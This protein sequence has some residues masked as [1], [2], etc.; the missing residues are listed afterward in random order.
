MSVSTRA[1]LLLLVGLCGLAAHLGG[2]VLLAF[3][4]AATLQFGL[5]GGVADL[6]GLRDE[7][8][9]I[10]VGTLSRG[11]R[12]GVRVPVTSG[13]TTHSPAHVHVRVAAVGHNVAMVHPWG[14][15][16][17]T[18]LVA[19]VGLNPL[20]VALAIL[21]LQPRTVRLIC[22]QTSREEAQR[23]TEVITAIDTEF[24]RTATDFA[25]PLCI[26]A[27][28][29]IAASAA[30][31]GY[32]AVL[33]QPFRLDYSG[34]TKVMTAAAVTEHLHSHASHPDSGGLWRTVVD[35]ASGTVINGATARRPHTRSDGL[36]IARIAALH[37]YTIS[38]TDLP[39]HGLPGL[40]DAIDQL[41]TRLDEIDKNSTTIWKSGTPAAAAVLPE[42]AALIG[43]HAATL[44]LPVDTSRL[45]D[46]AGVRGQLREI[47]VAH[48]LM[49]LV[50]GDPHAREFLSEAM[51]DGK[52]WEV[53]EDA[54][55]QTSTPATD[56]QLDLIVRSGHRVL[57]L[58]V[59]SQAKQANDY[60][61]ERLIP[62]R[63]PFGTA[64]TSVIASAVGVYLESDKS[65]F[66]SWDRVLQTA[67]QVQ[68]NL[69]SLRGK[70]TAWLVARETGTDEVTSGLRAW[71]HQSSAPPS[72]TARTVDR[73]LPLSEQSSI[74]V[75]ADGT[76]LAVKAALQWAGQRSVIALGPDTPHARD[77]FK[78]C[79]ESAKLA[80][81]RRDYLA[82]TIHGEHA[83][84]QALHRQRR[85]VDAV[86]VTP[87]PKVVTAG[88]IRY[89]V[90]HGANI[91]HIGID[92][93]VT[94]HGERQRDTLD[95]TP[96][97]T[98]ELANDYYTL[99]PAHEFPDTAIEALVGQLADASSRIDCWYRRPA[100]SGHSR[101][102]SP[103]DV[104]I[105]TGR[106]GCLSVHLWQPP[107]NPKKR[108][109]MFKSFQQQVRSLAVL[110]SARIGDAY[111][112]LLILRNGDGRRHMARYEHRDRWLPVLDDDEATGL[113]L[114]DESHA[115]I[116][117]HL[118]GAQTSV[119]P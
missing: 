61:T 23:I 93:S 73:A 37:G 95:F 83:T 72:I 4:L 112:P 3:L 47:L 43:T 67:E 8:R 15:D 38:G 42:F 94:T 14:D 13:T 91:V 11:D 103:P 85:H 36:T 50:H 40:D 49:H 81:S 44:G 108:A 18:H 26:D 68:A 9:L 87:G 79:A 25:D 51:F 17:P 21:T 56:A 82:V 34:G 54:E 66:V 32:F 101:P 117:G 53:G 12:T 104:F 5:L 76:P 60:L 10:H 35:D 96:N 92:G 65:T 111:K 84:Y 115:A 70:V 78:Q 100:D 16:E 69:P 27:E 57:V 86:V 99:S 62:A 107:D 74:S 114:S 45:N 80:H 105:L 102:H 55:E 98:V 116:V 41:W 31:A 20:P 97:W 63:W 109:A 39:E 88:L 24:G 106:R 46:V 89:A 29:L 52:A 113:I 90:E 77:A 58:E 22:S 33:P 19:T 64:V 118:H 75:A 59:K 2:Q 110:L 30:V 71:L 6:A 48:L 7:R 1:R 28:D 119:G